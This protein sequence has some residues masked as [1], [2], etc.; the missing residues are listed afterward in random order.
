[1]RVVLVHDF[2]TQ[3]G[4]AERV[5]QA[6][7]GLFP[8]APIYTLLYDE[9]IVQKH[10]S[11][12]VVRGSFLQ[13]LPAYMRMRHRLLLPLY[14][15]AI[16]RC[17]VRDFDIIISSSSAFAKGV[18][19]SPHATHICYCHA[20]ARF[21][22]EEQDQYLADNKYKGLI[23]YVVKYVLT[24]L[25]RRWDVASS[26]R[27]DVWIANSITTQRR[28]QQRYGR[29]AEIL[30]PPLTKLD[31]MGMHKE[32]RNEY[33]LVVSR[34]AAY[35]KINVIVEAFNI[36]G[37]PLVIVGDGAERTR[38]E[39]IARANITFT[40]FITDE[41]LAEHYQCAIA[42]IVACEEDFGISAIEALSFGAPVLA[43]RKGGVVEWAREGVTGE[44]FDEQTPEGVSFGVRK[45]LHNLTRYDP[46]HLQE[47]AQLFNE[48]AFRA[49]ILR[50]VSVEHGVDK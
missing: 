29:N 46:A 30:Y 24:P 40:G 3:F 31:R 23:K 45:I 39:K 42:L 4:G 6:L 10:F 12:K 8:D 44:M 20:T 7:T 48:D 49:G 16:G 2:L 25:L 18:K 41:A 14:P 36:L 37:L 9:K 21:L 27:V 22:W 28:I 15:Y 19:K 32:H 13:S 43:Y 35:K 47:T 17:N 11:G 1:M 38:L 33:F 5:L 26:R 50:L 34:L